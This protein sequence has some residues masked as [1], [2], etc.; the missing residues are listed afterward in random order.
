MSVVS[1]D[2]KSKIKEAKA[3]PALLLCAVYVL[4]ITST[5][6]S[7]LPFAF[8]P[9]LAAA[10]SSFIGARPPAQESQALQVN[11]PVPA[12]P[13]GQE[14]AVDLANAVFMTATPRP[15]EPTPTPVPD[16]RVLYASQPGD[17]LE[18]V[19]AHF[20]VAPGEISSLDGMLPLSGLIPPGQTLLVPVSIDGET[21]PF[22]NLLPDSEV[23]YSA[24]ALDF[25]TQ[26]VTESADAFLNSYVEFVPYYKDAKG[27]E[28]IEYVGLSYS[29][30]PR[31]LMALLEYQSGW[32]LGWPETLEEEKYPLGFINES[33][34]DLHPQTV[35]A[36]KQISIGYYGW[37]E[38]TLT[39]IVFKDGSTMRLAPTLNAGTVGLMYYFAQIS[40]REQWQ[41]MI[42]PA[43]GFA[44]F[45]AHLFDDPWARAAELGDL[46]P[47][48][49]SQPEL[50][51]P[52][53][54]GEVWSYSSGPHG[55][56][57]PEGSQG[58]LDFAPA[59][60]L[61]GCNPSSAWVVASAD[62]V[63]TRLKPGLLVLDL[64]GDGLEQ[65]GW[66]MIYMH[67]RLEEDSQLAVG[68]MVKQGEPL[69]HP[70]CLLGTSTATHI[71]VARKHNGEWV[72]AVGALPFVLGGWQAYAG[73][74]AYHGYMIRGEQMI[75]SCRCA[76]IDA[77]IIRTEDVPQVD[78]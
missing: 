40:D 35:A 13:A 28:V 41:K 58:A 54:I 12:S 7:G 33:I 10:S 48:G 9:E 39:E 72:A 57:V 38:G 3:L 52:F 32:L 44:A 2:N 18:V 36:A 43:D 47:A 27:W 5:R 49:V 37:R 20:G 78:Q 62:G 24:S 26:E 25:N 11:A 6:C 63:I 21:T 69:G 8:I 46:F 4:L 29:I 66:V 19:A 77:R 73:D 34:P 22:V 1:K 64:D 75:E 16:D 14:P 65:T 56:W 67:L 50:I 76:S 31:L 55:S 74:E 53:E 17:S 60:E 30:S 23:V 59:S 15:V 61:R 71:H 68:S 45:Y 42:D 51:L 70:S